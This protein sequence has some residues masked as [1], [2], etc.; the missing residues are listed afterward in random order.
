MR[1]IATVIFCL[2]ALAASAAP[3]YDVTATVTAPAT[4]GPVD[5]YTLVLNG[6]DVGPVV[7]GQN[8]FPNLLTADGTYT[9]T[10]RATNAAG[11]ALS[12]PVTVTV[13]ELTPPGAPGL[14]IQIDCSPCVISGQ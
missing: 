1:F 4:G 11:S 14:T 2:M 12:A 3:P 5:V 10:V 8:S 9:F 6:A 13:T 7:V